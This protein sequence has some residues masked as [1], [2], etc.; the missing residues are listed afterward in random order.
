MTPYR[1]SLHED[2]GDKVTLLFFCMADDEDHA[3]EQAIDFYPGC[4]IINV[5]Q[6]DVADLRQPTQEAVTAT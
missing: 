5:T 6:G 3:E 2:P 1:V 4:E